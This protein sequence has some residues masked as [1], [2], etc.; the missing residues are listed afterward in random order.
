MR[1]KTPVGTQVN[2]MGTDGKIIGVIE[3][4]HN[5]PVFQEINPLILTIQPNHYDYFLQYAF[6][7]IKSTHIPQTLKYV[8]AGAKEFAPD[9]PFEYYFLDEE[10]EQNYHFAYRI[11]RIFNYFAFFAIFISCLGLF[12]LALF[13]GESRRKEVGIRKV[14]GASIAEILVVFNKQFMKWILLSNLIGWPIAYFA[15]QKILQNSVYRIDISLY[16]FL[17]T[18]LITFFIALLTVSFQS[19]KTAFSNPVEALRYE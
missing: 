12:A 15:A 7:K 19:I 5:R 3:D 1:L 4:F 14:L 11:G 17:F 9:Y 6:V 13:M 18:G 16:I 8:E 2:F 10:F